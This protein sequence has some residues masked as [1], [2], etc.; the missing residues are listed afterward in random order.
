MSIISFLDRFS[1]EESCKQDFLQQRLRK[2]VVC[3]KC[4]SG[5]HYWLESK[6]QF[7]CS[8]CRFR[9]TLRSGTVLESTKLPYRYWYIAIHL[10]TSTKKGFSAHELQR[11]IGHKRYEPIWYLMQKIR[12]SMGKIESKLTLKDMVSYDDAYV[13]TYTENADKTD[14]KRGKGS[15]KK[16]KIT[17]MP[18]SIPLE[19]N[20]KESS[21]MGNV[22][23]VMNLEETKEAA[24]Q[25]A[26]DSIDTTSVVFSDKGSNYVDFKTI[27]EENIQH[28]SDS[29]NI[30]LDFKWVN[31]TIA[32]L[33]R[34]L[35]GIYHFVKE[36]Y[37]QYYLDEFTY[38]LNKRN[39]KQKFDYL[40]LNSI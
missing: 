3:K 26:E 39:V 13:S 8:Q 20:G 24:N 1:T 16:S 23:I 7:Q 2:G 21:F 5:K 15:Q 22:K 6:E 31:V 36:E 29:K 9:T 12:K 32:N 33:K 38:K 17:V 35:L 11:Q 4:G 25:V 28:K 40:I 37:L 19:E 34:F 10:M 18:E 14:L 30:P 27:F